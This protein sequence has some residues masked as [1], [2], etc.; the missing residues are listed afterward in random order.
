M[1]IGMISRPYQAPSDLEAM[2]QLLL[3]ARSAEAISDYPS[4]VDLRQLFSLKEIRSAT[5]IWETEEG[6]LTGFA[7]VDS[8]NNLLFELD[9]HKATPEVEDQVIAWGLGHISQDYI[10][11]QNGPALDATCRSEDNARKTFLERHG[12][13]RVPGEAVIMIRSL[14]G[15]IP[16]PILPPG[17]TIRPMKGE[18]E[19]E[20]YVALHRD[21]FGTRNMT[22]EARLAIMHSPDYIPELDL[23]A[24]DPQGTLAALCVCRIPPRDHERSGHRRGWT[25]PVAT[26]PFYRRRGLSKALL[27]TG[28]Q[29]LMARGLQEALLPTNG[30]NIPMIRAANEAGFT[31]RSTKYWYRKT[32]ITDPLKT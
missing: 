23:V 15:A 14:T 28:L 21:A 19:I 11:D 18:Q 26:H 3:T 16:S 8:V 20:A 12:F 27:L 22:K 24:V 13:V 1:N 30:D 2:I 25:D 17:F 9:P 10:V 32:V 5:Q 7:L 29:L 6:Q 4:V 31:I